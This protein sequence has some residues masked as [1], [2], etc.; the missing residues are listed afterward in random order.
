MDKDVERIQS[1]AYS[2]GADGAYR[3]ILE[4]LMPTKEDL[5]DNLV[6]SKAERK[7]Y[8]LL[9][10]KELKDKVKRARAIYKAQQLVIKG[11]SQLNI[12]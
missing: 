5:W 11:M 10:I 12:D 8:I 4:I 1:Q 6:F 3:E 9:S 2:D 7:K